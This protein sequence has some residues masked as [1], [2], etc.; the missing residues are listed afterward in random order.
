[1]TFLELATC[2]CLAKPFNREGLRE[3]VIA[4]ARR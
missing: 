4:A 1:M 2:T 3:A